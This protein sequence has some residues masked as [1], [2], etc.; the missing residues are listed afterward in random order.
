MKGV[1]NIFKRFLNLLMEATDSNLE[2]AIEKLYNIYNEFD[3][4][5]MVNAK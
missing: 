3:K 2:L 1:S 5:Y 4:E